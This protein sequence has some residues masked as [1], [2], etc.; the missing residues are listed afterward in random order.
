MEIEVEKSTF[1]VRDVF[2]HLSKSH[3]KWPTQTQTYRETCGIFADNKTTYPFS[4]WIDNEILYK[5]FSAIG[6]NYCHSDNYK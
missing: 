2:G 1:Q 6:F 3:T 4:I 5:P